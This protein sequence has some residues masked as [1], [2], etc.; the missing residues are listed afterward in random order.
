MEKE[1]LVLTAVFPK[2]CRWMFFH[3]TT[4]QAK[5]LRAIEIVY[6]IHHLEAAVILH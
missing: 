3:L 2:Q 1:D 6:P 4:L 5:P